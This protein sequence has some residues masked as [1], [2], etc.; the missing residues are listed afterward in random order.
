MMRTMFIILTIILSPYFLL[1]QEIFKKNL[2][3][4]INTSFFET[5]PL[6][7]PDG[8]TLYF[9]RQNYPD[10]IDGEMDEQDIYY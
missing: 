4:S 8:Q 9:A 6:I 1:S 7:S 3:D 10:N 5:K 2:G